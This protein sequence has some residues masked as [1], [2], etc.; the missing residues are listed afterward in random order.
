[1]TPRT[2]RLLAFAGAV[3]AMLIL[4]RSM[5]VLLTE[6]WWAASISEAAA[7]ATTRWTLFGW[8]LDAVAISLASV[9]FTLH[10]LLVVRGIASVTVAQRVGNEQIP[11]AISPR[12]LAWWSVG[13]GV[14]L[15]TLTGV[16]TRSWRWAILLWDTGVH[17][18]R[19]E[20]TAGAD[21]GVFVARLPVWQF[22]LD[23]AFTLTLLALALVLVL[24]FATGGLRRGEGRDLVVHPH[25]RRHLGGLLALLALLVGCA[26][27][28][29]PWTTIVALQEPLSAMGASVRG[30]TAQAMFGAAVAVAAMS[31]GWAIRDRHS[32]LLASWIVLALALGAERVVI[33]IMTGSDAAVE[34]TDA[35]IR[36]ATELA[37]GINLVVGAP[38]PDTL[39]MITG[40]WDAANFAQ[41]VAGRS[42]TLL[43]ATAGMTVLG[44]SLQPIWYV[45]MAR[46]ENGPAFEAVT[47]REGAEPLRD[48]TTL[49][50]R[51]TRDAVR[52]RPDAPTWR[53]VSSGVR[54]GSLP[55]RLL[56]A[57]G[58]QAGG[59]LRLP[60]SAS[61]DWNLDPAARAAALLPF[62][63]WLPGELVVV[64]GRPIWITQGVIPIAHFPLSGT[65]RWGGRDVAGIA[66]AFLALID[67]WTG[68]VEV[69]PDPG[70]NALGLAWVRIA[71]DLVAPAGTLSPAVRDAVPYP[72]LLLETQLHQLEGQAWSLGRRPG[73]RVPDGP[74]EAPTPTWTRSDGAGWQ[75]V[76]EDPE[77]RVMT[78]ILTATRRD[79]LPRITVVRHGG[80][81]PENGREAER[82]W[83]R[84]PALNRLRDSARAARDS[85]V[86]G[87]VRW[88]LGPAG[89][90]AWQPLVALNRFGRVT[91]IVVGTAGRGRVAADRDPVAAWQG[92]LGEADSP[93]LP[94]EAQINAELV[95]KAREWLVRADSAMARGDL[96]AFGRAFEALRTLLREPPPE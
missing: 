69:H 68:A 16:G 78:G 71:G 26:S 87:T 81:G 9:W 91:A 48:S 50:S 70:A 6:R 32:L 20:P 3:V 31:I 22:L 56:L 34:G 66:P 8:L 33:P 14:L 61:V 75:S 13:I 96:T 43:S 80:T 21:L 77:R 51:I 44:D 11:V 86:A 54:V 40:R 18:N 84:L 10:A 46:E 94:P 25:T 42:A 37:W 24:Y 67:P 63:S 76:F 65:G 5:A 64:D 29:H 79:G 2:R 35:A 27:L 19:T 1:M 52:L 7:S 82:S 39:P 88:H 30:V 83:N 23:F 12:V 45:A 53:Q 47:L 62:A 28:L 55:R 95:R 92:V 60:S 38:S 58:R 73:R 41:L 90:L 72:R 89:L 15:G 74:P 49:L 36:D 17:F 85:V 93:T 57:W 4:G 59:M